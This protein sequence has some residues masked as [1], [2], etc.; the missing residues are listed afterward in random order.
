MSW[1]VSVGD[2]IARVTGLTE[3]EAIGQGSL[4]VVDSANKKTA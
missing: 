3:I 2:E 4:K 1:L